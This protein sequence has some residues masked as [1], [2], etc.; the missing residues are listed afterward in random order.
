[1]DK[2]IQKIQVLG[3]ILL[4]PIIFI[5]FITDR[6]IGSFLFWLQLPSMREY[7]GGSN[8]HFMTSLYRVGFVAFCLFVYKMIL[9]IS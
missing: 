7:F 3:G 1:M 5:L 8:K 4:L 6:A 2:K 9:L